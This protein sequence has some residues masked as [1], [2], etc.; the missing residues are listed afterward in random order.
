VT[1]YATY[2]CGA[3]GEVFQK[4]LLVVKTVGFKKL[5]T[6]VDIQSRVASWL[7]PGCLAK[8]PDW[9]RPAYSGQSHKSEAKERAKAVRD[10]ILGKIRGGEL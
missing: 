2:R 6:R 10:D 1:G 9:N 5:G 4:E 3:C 7:C 8:D